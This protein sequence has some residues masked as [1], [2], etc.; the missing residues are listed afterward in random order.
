MGVFGSTLLS[1]SNVL[2]YKKHLVL[3]PRVVPI[4]FVN[5]SRYD[6]PGNTVNYD[7]K[8]KSI[9]ICDD[10]ASYCSAY[11]IGQMALYRVF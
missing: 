5:N 11:N 10:Y 3:K 2:G 1:M 4:V 9:V 6:K 8:Q 7:G